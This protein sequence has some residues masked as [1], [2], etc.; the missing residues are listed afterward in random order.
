[1]AAGCSQEGRT[2][3][4]DPRIDPAPC[5][6]LQDG[7]AGLLAPGVVVEAEPGIRVTAPAEEACPAVWQV[8][9]DASWAQ[10]LSATFN[11]ILDGADRAWE[12]IT[13]VPTMTIP[14]A[15]VWEVSYQARGAAGMPANVPGSEYVVAG[16][17]KNGAFM[18]GSEAMVVGVVGQSNGVQGTGGQGFLHSFAAGD[19]VRLHAY[20]IG[21]SG[22]A[23]LMSNGDGRTRIWAH[24]LAPVGDGAA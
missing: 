19:T 11:H 14:R 12:P 5:N 10:T 22:S 23:S 17:F 2:Y 15:G 13:A 3:R 6:A 9:V 20:R 7:A 1:M 24:W 8:G 21:Q 4:I 16:L 18:P